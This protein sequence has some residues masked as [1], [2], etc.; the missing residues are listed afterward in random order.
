[1]S[2]LIGAGI[3]SF[4]TDWVA[5]PLKQQTEAEGGIGIA[6]L[7]RA[8]ICHF[9]TDSVTPLFEPAAAFALADR[10]A[11]LRG[12]L[13]DRGI[14]ALLDCDGERSRRVLAVL[15]LHFDRRFQRRLADRCALIIS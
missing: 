7:V 11:A 14:A 1:M 8:T 6:A 5:S 4:R 12:R 9:G 3:G 15:R 10:A 13:T 2:P